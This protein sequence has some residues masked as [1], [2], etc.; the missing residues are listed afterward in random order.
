MSSV[1]SRRA[2]TLEEGS[3]A[4]GTVCSLP[5]G[6]LLT[7]KGPTAPSSHHSLHSKMA[8]E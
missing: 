7:I 2:R 8:W 3:P 1:A 6:L 5:V 4:S